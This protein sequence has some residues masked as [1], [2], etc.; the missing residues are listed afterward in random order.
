M[1]K[2][3]P[4]PKN[5]NLQ[6]PNDQNSVALLRELSHRTAQSSS[7]G[8]VNPAWQGRAAE[9]KSAHFSTPATFLVQLAPAADKIF[10]KEIQ[11]ADWFRMFLQYG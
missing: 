3:Q 9:Q 2:V 8:W 7:F 5:N 10:G 4:A 6:V 11:I 1:A